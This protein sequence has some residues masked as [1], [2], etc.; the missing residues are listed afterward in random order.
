MQNLYYCLTL[1]LVL[2]AKPGFA[3]IDNLEDKRKQIDQFFGENCKRLDHQNKV[4]A[5]SKDST[6]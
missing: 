6:G 3:Q 1:S 5:D 4:N 2:L